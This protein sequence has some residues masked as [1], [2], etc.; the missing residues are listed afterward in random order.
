MDKLKVIFN[1]FSTSLL[2]HDTIFFINYLVFTQ[3]NMPAF[4]HL[5][6]AIKYKCIQYT[7]IHSMLIQSN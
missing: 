1:N 5:S 3:F 4:S 6:P 7:I 2:K